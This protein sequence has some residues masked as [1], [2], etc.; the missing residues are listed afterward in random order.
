MKELSTDPRRPRKP[1]DLAAVVTLIGVA[2]LSVTMIFLFALPRA[3][4]FLPIPGSG[5]FTITDV[6]LFA[7]TFGVFVLVVGMSLYGIRSRR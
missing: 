5:G 6:A 3:L 2:L 1:L 7:F 4:A